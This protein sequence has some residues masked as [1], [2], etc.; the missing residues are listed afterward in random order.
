ME[1]WVEDLDCNHATSNR[2]R[3]E[4]GDDGPADSEDVHS[5]SDITMYELVC[6]YIECQIMKERPKTD[7]EIKQVACGTKAIYAV[8]VEVR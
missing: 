5:Q 1:E 7:T 2:W 3:L 4:Q 8:A 6:V